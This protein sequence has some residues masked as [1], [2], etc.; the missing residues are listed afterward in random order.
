MQST[1]FIMK[2]GFNK[3]IINDIVDDIVLDRL[4]LS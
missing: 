1:V 3:T 2:V 4:N